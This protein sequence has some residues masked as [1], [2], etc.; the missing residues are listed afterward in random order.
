MLPL[1]FIGATHAIIV[2]HNGGSQLDRPDLRY[3]DDDGLQY[4]A[5][6]RQAGAQVTLLTQLDRESQVLN[7]SAIIDG[8]PTRDALATAVRNAAA[9]DE[10]YIVLAGHGDVREGQGFLSL[11]DGPLNADELEQRVIVPLDK[12]RVH[13]I[14]DSCNSYFMVHQRKPGGT[15]FK[16]Q[17]PT[18]LLARHPR[19]SVLLSTSA[20]AVTYEWSELQSGIFSYVVRSALRGAADADGDGVISYPEAVTFVQVATQGIENDLYRPHVYARSAQTA[21]F[22]MPR[23]TKNEL[24]VDG[25]HRLTL[26]NEKGVRLADVHS[27]RPLR[28]W[29]PEERITIEERKG[30]RIVQ[31]EIGPAEQRKLSTLTETQP[32]IVVRGESPVFRNLFAQPFGA[33]AMAQASSQPEEDEA[34]GVSRADVERWKIVLAER[35]KSERQKR[36]SD[37]WVTG[38]ESAAML[39]AGVPLLALGIANGVNQSTFVGGALAIAGVLTPA[40][41]LPVLLLRKTTSERLQLELEKTPLDTQAAR[42]IA[43]QRIS[44]HMFEM[45]KAQRRLQLVGGILDTVVAAGMGGL[46]AS[47]FNVAAVSRDQTMTMVGM[48]MAGASAAFLVNAIWKLSTLP[49]KID[50]IEQL[51]LREKPRAVTFDGVS[52]GADAKGAYGAVNLRF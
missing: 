13:L 39:G 10:V 17:Q 44:T 48:I 5:L 18:G 33:G 26:R 2:T 47:Y 42:S 52:V 35:A 31:R 15:A 1:L 40:I 49:P 46:A 11:A 6:F 16:T 24:V 34:Y 45:L 23:V 20:E 14:I 43:I 8:P 51:E 32:S 29:L 37:A 28:L 3:A 12:T 22:L 21:L 7:P 4:A 30:Q 25:A 9:A 36:I 41:A 50:S 38:V 19:L 27:E